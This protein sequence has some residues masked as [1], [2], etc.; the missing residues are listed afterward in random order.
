MI[1][2]NSYTKIIKK[3]YLNVSPWGVANIQAF[4]D[5]FDTFVSADHQRIF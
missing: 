5:S 1:Y 2:F 4:Y 3:N